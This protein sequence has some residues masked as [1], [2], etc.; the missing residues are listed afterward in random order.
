[1]SW[2]FMLELDRVQTK[3]LD[4]IR[5]VLMEFLFY[6]DNG[7]LIEGKLVDDLRSYR[8]EL[9][10]ALLSNDLIKN[11]YSLKIEDNTVF[12]LDE[13]V[14]MLR[15]KQYWGNDYTKYANDIGLTSEG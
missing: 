8:T 1:M 10:Q 12:K 7:E 6:W 9:I 11:T 15:F 4:E 3:L 5:N 13:F 14:S 2:L